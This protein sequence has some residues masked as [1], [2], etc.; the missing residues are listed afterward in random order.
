MAISIHSGVLW[1]Y[2]ES[3]RRTYLIGVLPVTIYSTLKTGWSGCLGG[4]TFRGDE[5]LWDASSAH[6]WKRVMKGV[7][8]KAIG[9][10]PIFSHRMGDVLPN[11]KPADV[12][13]FTCT[14]LAAS[15]GRERLEGWRAL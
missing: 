2:I 11:R 4:I 3:I 8:E 15:F 1:A 6:A 7:N 9:F 14:L 10:I 5:G 12:D 13:D